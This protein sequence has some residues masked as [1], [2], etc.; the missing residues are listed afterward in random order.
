MSVEAKA[1]RSR[2]S[3]TP[4]S[5]VTSLEVSSLCLFYNTHSCVCVCVILIISACR[6]EPKPLTSTKLYLKSTPAVTLQ[7][8]SRLST[9]RL[10]FAHFLS[11]TTLRHW[12]FL[13]WILFEATKTYEKFHQETKQK[14]SFSLCILF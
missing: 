8:K 2:V 14:I 12:S 11:G 13:Y 10:I 3:Q 6:C 7:L 4:L 9:V 1:S 5:R